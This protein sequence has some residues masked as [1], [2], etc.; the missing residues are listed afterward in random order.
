MTAGRAAVARS[1]VGDHRGANLSVLLVLLLAI[2]GLGLGYLLRFAVESQ[3]VAVTAGGVSAMVPARWLVTTGTGTDTFAFVAVDPRGAEAT[4]TAALIPSDTGDA[5]A[6]ARE[7]LSQDRA[8]REGFVLL[9]GS[10]VRLAERGGYRVDYSYVGP[11][12]ADGLPVVLRGVGLYFG[13]G[14]DVLALTYEDAADRFERQ[15]DRF[16][17]FAASARAGQQ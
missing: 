14:D 3:T 7:H 9:D 15:L 11:A 13:E 12:G 6:V 17:R 2:G 4:I 5:E 8:M 16:F 10:A 1:V